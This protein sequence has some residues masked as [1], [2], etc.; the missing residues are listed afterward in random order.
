MV[1]ECSIRVPEGLLGFGFFHASM[2]VIYR[3]LVPIVSIV[4]PFGG[5]LLG[6]LI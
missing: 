4:V 5:Y 1:S 6:S 2:Q 3:D